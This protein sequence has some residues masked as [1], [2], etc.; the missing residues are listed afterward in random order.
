[1]RVNSCLPGRV[2]AWLVMALAGPLALP[3]R[4]QNPGLVS[5]C[6][7]ALAGRVADHESG[8]V[9]PGATARLLE[10][11]EVS[12]ADPYGNYHF[13]VCAGT[14]HLEVSFVGFRSETAEVRVASSVVRNFQLHPDAVQLAGAVVRGQALVAPPTQAT[15]ALTGRD[16]AATR[17]QSLGEALLKVSGVSAIQTGPN[18]FKPMIHGLHSN[19]VA[20]LNNGVRQEGQQWGQD[21]GPE[22][23]PFVASQLTVVKGAAGVRYGAD[24]IG[25][26]VLAQP[27][28]LPD[29]AGT[30]ADLHLVGASN[31]GLGAASA[32]V[33][34]RPRQA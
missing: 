30:T 28:A 5:A 33:Q 8:T 22:I 26:V 21:H 19:R 1:M 17:G 2:A 24:A 31:N 34:G 7:L 4:A 10:T 15:A 27:A 14:Y 3:S 25:G 16:L 6:T 12:A 11:G 20:L 9:L 23:D 32:T 18:V 13:H 29:S